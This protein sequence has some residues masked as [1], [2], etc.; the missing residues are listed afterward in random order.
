MPGHPTSYLKTRI[1]GSRLQNAARLLV[2]VELSRR[3][4]Q[5]YRFAYDKQAADQLLPQDP[6]TDNRSII[7]NSGAANQSC[8]I[9]VSFTGS[10][11]GNLNGPSIPNSEK[12]S[13]Y[14]IGFSVK[15][16]G[17]SGNI[18]LRSNPKNPRPKNTWLVEQWIADFNFRNG[19]VVRHDT[20]SEMDELA[21]AYPRP[22][23]DGDSVSWYDHPGTPVAGT[24]GYF[25]KRNFYIKAY[26]GKR[27][28]EV[29]FHLTFRVFNK[30]IVLPEWG[31]GL[32]K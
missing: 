16:S 28:C 21:R 11:D 19:E 23:R 25:T 24:L 18:A 3:L 30:Q 9:E 27:H 29:A 14:G 8:K 31:P 1:R 10:Y 7:D 4:H 13:F 5:A 32:Y 15:I 6:V 2:L 22:R 17:L 12:G 26:R 20:V